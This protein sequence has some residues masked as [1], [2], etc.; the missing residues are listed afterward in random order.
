MFL[1]N[2]TEVI[3]PDWMEQLLMYAQRKDVGA[4]GAKLYYADNTIQ[5]CIRDSLREDCGWLEII[6]E[7]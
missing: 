6:C 4:V 5:M 7:Q 2:D 3:S 1:N